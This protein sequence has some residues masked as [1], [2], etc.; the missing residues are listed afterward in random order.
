M[1]KPFLKTL[2]ERDELIVFRKI[3]DEFILVPNFH[4]REDIGSIYT[5]NP[6]AA[7]IWE[8]LDGKSAVDEIRDKIVEEWDVTSSAAENDLVEFLNQLLGIGAIK[9]VAD[10]MSSSPET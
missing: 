9:E 7:Y 2:F 4:K 1:T 6:V 10:G 5:M 8:S 3:D